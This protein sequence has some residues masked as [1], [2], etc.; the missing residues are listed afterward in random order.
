MEFLASPNNLSYSFAY[1]F[2]IIAAF[3]TCLYTIR[4]FIYVFLSRPNYNRNIDNLIEDPDKLMFIPMLILALFAIFG[5]YIF[6]N[7]YKDIALYIHP[8]HYIKDYNNNI[9]I[10][11]PLIFLLLLLL[12]INI[13]YYNSYHSINFN[14]IPTNLLIVDHF[15]IINHKI[16]FS[17]LNTSINLNRYLDKGLIDHFGY[18][19][20]NR[21]MNF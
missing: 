17:Y 11:I 5:G 13:N 2:T 9:L 7:I 4:S 1:I 14:N 6:S 8:N 18:L 19:G 16:K 15:N 21:L 10:Y 12:F 20:I 3:F